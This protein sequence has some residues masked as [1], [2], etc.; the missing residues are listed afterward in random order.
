[1]MT[2]L[3]LMILRIFAQVVNMVSVAHV[4]R[5]ED[6]LVHLE[7]SAPEEWDKPEEP[8][9]PLID[10]WARGVV[11][12][13]RPLSVNSSVHEDGENNAFQLMLLENNNKPLRRASTMALCQYQETMARRRSSEV[14]SKQGLRGSLR[15]FSEGF[16]PLE[17][18]RKVQFQEKVVSDDE[19]VRVGRRSST[20]PPTEFFQGN[21]RNPE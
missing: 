4:Q 3:G 7:G 5:M 20:P 17:P 15:R 18:N 13:K 14:Y 8:L 1:M 2:L 16:F 11:P 6:W 9:I 21:Q 19:E 12:I 10:S